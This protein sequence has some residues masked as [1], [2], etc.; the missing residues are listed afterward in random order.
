MTRSKALV[1]IF[2]GGLLLETVAILG[3]A[4]LG[5]RGELL[6]LGAFVPLT[7]MAYSSSR[8]IRHFGPYGT[9]PRR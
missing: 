6:S 1:A 2:S 9:P 7:L 8:V 3:M 4:A 5:V